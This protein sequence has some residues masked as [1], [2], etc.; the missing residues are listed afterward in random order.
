MRLVDLRGAVPL[1]SLVKAAE[2]SV[3]DSLERLEGSQPDGP[4]Q[5]RASGTLVYDDGSAV[6][7]SILVEAF[8]AKELEG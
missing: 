7:V 2:I 1:R 5:V 4:S 8:S 6:Q 3:A